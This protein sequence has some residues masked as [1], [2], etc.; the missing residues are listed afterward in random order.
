MKVPFRPGGSY[1]RIQSRERFLLPTKQG[2]IPHIQ[3][4]CEAKDWGKEGSTMPLCNVPSHCPFMARPKDAISPKNKLNLVVLLYVTI[5]FEAD[6]HSLVLL[7]SSTV[8]SL[9]NA[10]C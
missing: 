4:P 5:S 10:C 3:V 7:K 2:P 6:D 9:R 1:N 8:A